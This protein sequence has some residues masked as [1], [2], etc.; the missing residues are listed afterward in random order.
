MNRIKELRMTLIILLVG[1]FFLSGCFFSNKY[2]VSFKTNGGSEVENIQVKSGNTLDEPDTPKK[3]GFVF[4]GWYLDGEEYDFDSEVKKDM[5]LV[6]KWRKVDIGD[7]TGNEDPSNTTVPG[8]TTEEIDTTTKNTNKVIFTTTTIKVKTTKKKTTTKKITTTELASTKN[9]TTTTTK[10]TT[11]TTTEKVTE[12]PKPTDPVNP[13]VKEELKMQIIATEIIP[14]TTETTDET[15]KTETEVPETPEVVPNKFK[16]EIKFASDEINVIS[17]VTEDELQEILTSDKSKWVLY[18]NNGFVYENNYAKAIDSLTLEGDVK[19][20]SITI[21]V[22]VDNQVKY[23]TLDEVVTKTTEVL[24]DRTQIIEDVK[25]YI[26]NANVSLTTKKVIS[27][28]STELPALDPVM[29]TYYYADLETA[30]KLA[31]N[32][33]TVTILRDINVSKTIEI[34]KVFNLIGNNHKVTYVENIDPTN[35]GYISI[36]N[37]LFIVKDIDSIEG[38][39]KFENIEFD[40]KSFMHIQNTA[41]FKELQLNNVKTKYANTNILNDSPTAQLVCDPNTSFAIGAL[42]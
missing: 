40:V 37:Y 13:D 33:D 35:P 11:T 39:I 36:V 9:T 20:N 34:N 24:D 28:D 15:E 16:Y 14:E 26:N 27:E 12:P 6:A 1:M 29:E 5:T 22:T 42:L 23:Y 4:E 7:N 21:G 25:W 3:E 31:N 17:N 10:K 38:I 19:T 41:S 32:E 18:N 30:I 8:G 2:E